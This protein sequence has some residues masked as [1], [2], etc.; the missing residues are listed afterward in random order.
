MFRLR[1][2]PQE[3]SSSGIWTCWLFQFI[4]RKFCTLKPVFPCYFI[5]FT[6]QKK[7]GIRYQYVLSITKPCKLFIASFATFGTCSRF[8][9][10]KGLLFYLEL[11]VGSSVSD[12]GSLP[13]HH[14]LYP[15]QHPPETQPFCPRVRPRSDEVHWDSRDDKDQETWLQ[16]K[17]Q[18]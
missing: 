14:P 16:R 9:D 4:L 3:L 6:F 13:P 1:L 2:C 5:F 10:N 17:T 18:I 8:N 7:L 12:P 15:T 11:P